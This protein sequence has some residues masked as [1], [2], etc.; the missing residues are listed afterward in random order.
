MPRS[1]QDI[2][3]SADELADAFEAWD[4]TPDQER[5]P[6]PEMLLRRAAYKRAEAERQIADA[7]VAARAADVPWRVIGESIG[8][9]AQSAQ[10]RYRT[11]V[12]IAKR[13]VP[14]AT[15]LV[16]I[17]KRNTR[18]AMGTKS[19]QQVAERAARASKP[20]ARPSAAAGRTKARRK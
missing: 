11:L 5:T 8:T 2:L 4:P 12:R 1:L 15:R 7:V 14:I 20:A 10:R 6:T 18:I 16:P 19:A 13:N 9:T 17:A 3:D